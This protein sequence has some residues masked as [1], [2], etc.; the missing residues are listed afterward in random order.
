[1][2]KAGAVT[3]H[4]ALTGIY[5]IKKKVKFTSV[6]VKLF[7]PVVVLGLGMAERLCKPIE[8]GSQENKVEPCKPGKAT[9]DS[10]I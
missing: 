2:R 10:K 3:V 8:L 4:S 1:M 6:S 7:Q 9:A 5:K